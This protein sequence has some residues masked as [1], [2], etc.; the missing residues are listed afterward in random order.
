MISIR[1]EQFSF[2]Y[3]VA[4]F[5]AIILSTVAVATISKDTSAVSGSDFNAGNIIQDRNFYNNSSMSAAEIQAFLNS[6]VPTCSSGYTCLKSYSQNTPNRSADGLCGYY[7]GG[8]KVA[9]QIIYDVGLVCGVNPQVLITLLQKEQAL[10][11]STRPSSTQYASATGYAC[12][13][14]AA[15]DPAFAGFFG[16]VYKAAWQYKYYAKYSDSYSYRPYRNNSI[17]WSPTTSCGRSNVTIENQSTASLYIYT[18]YRPNQAALNNLYGTGDSCSAYGN[19]N[20]WRIFSDWFGIDNKALIRTA[21]SGDLYYSTGQYKYRVTSMDVAA[22]YGFSTSDVAFVSQSTLDSIQNAPN[23]PT[24]NYIVKSD[25]DSDD[26]GGN[27]Y[28]VTG[29]QRHLITSMEQFANFGLSTNNLTQLPYYSLVRLPLAGNLSNF[30]YDSTGFVYK[31]E[32]GTKSG[33]FQGTLFNQLNP[34]GQASRLSDF[35]LSNLRTITPLIS[36]VVTLQDSNGALWSATS[37]GWNYIP[38]MNVAQC[39]GAASNIIRVTPTQAA[40][41]TRLDNA[42]CVAKKEGDQTL[43]LLDGPN[44][45]PV[46]S[47]WGITN[48]ATLD[49]SV[50]NSKQTINLSANSV[51]KDSGSGSLYLLQNNKKR[52]IGDMLAVQQRGQQDSIK[53]VSTPF[54]SELAD[55]PEVYSTGTSVIDTSGNI[56]I[57]HN[58]Q[59]LYVQSMAILRAY[60]YSSSSFVRLN[61]STLSAYPTAGNLEQK[62]VIGS[63]KF[64]FDK[65]IGWSIPDTLLSAYGMTG[66][67]P[68][69]DASVAR[70]ANPKQPTRYIKS[71]SSAQ[72]YYLDNG[73]KRPVYSWDAFVGLGGNNQNITEYSS[74]TLNQF[75]TGASY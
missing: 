14:T 47:E 56:F 43:Y 11:T 61:D 33:I 72:L 42:S 28:L 23:N 10:I 7:Q 25:S 73:T 29:R 39:I 16:Q 12:P 63:N 59:K 15:C 69:Y 71:D 4:G 24:L 26:D 8:N 67:L 48:A 38:S 35:A 34:S 36:G 18:P 5:L 68:T 51:F 53:T 70:Y 6:K 1:K 65:S 74:T 9:A 64:L 49:A 2:I 44:K 57:I 46:V 52:Y 17:L 55:G 75:P 30:V 58:N 54:L 60:G 21:S 13:D 37:S 41:G 50:L 62:S 40:Q 31:V 32:N 66:T 27:I 3:I 22:E 19:R 20:F 45:Y